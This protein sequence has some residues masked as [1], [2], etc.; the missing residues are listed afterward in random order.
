M[1]GL[2]VLVKSDTCFMG[3]HC[4]AY[5]KGIVIRFFYEINSWLQYQGTC[6]EQLVLEKLVVSL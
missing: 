5:A 4:E 2:P 3:S 1:S 6:I